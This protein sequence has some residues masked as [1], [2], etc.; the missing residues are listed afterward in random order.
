MMGYFSRLMEQTGMTAGSAIDSVPKTLGQPRTRE[1][2]VI[3]PI[4]LDH[5]E[6]VEPQENAAATPED[7]DSASEL[8][9]LSVEDPV[10]QNLGSEVPQVT[11]HP[12]M[13]KKLHEQSE[14]PE[15]RE[16]IVR[17]SD[18]T[19]PQRGTAARESLEVEVMADAG[20]DLPS[21]TV[22][23][24]A[25]GVD[26]II[27]SVA[28]QEDERPASG[29]RAPKQ[30]LT[31]Q[32][33]RKPRNPTETWQG[34]VKEIREWVA[35]TPAVS[36]AEV[37]NGVRSQ[38]GLTGP[39]LPLVERER[40]AASYPNRAT[41]TPGPETRDLH[42]AIGTI[43]VTVEEPR[44]EIKVRSSGDQAQQ[45]TNATNGQRSRLG[46]HYITW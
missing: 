20:R 9:I 10:E 29:D 42:L 41:P 5:I 14:P 3:A 32:P 31:G 7:P 40:F 8:S 23:Q 21:V 22:R 36:D 18:T 38:P 28:S 30:A 19:F 43:S 26:E 12:P 15:E 34:A 27:E 6:P 25:P 16:F 35:E 2:G 13:R 17:D 4:D 11:D 1:A 24:G 45:T 44:T 37:E 46:R 39:E 33:D